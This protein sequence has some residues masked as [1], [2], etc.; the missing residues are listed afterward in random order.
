M[1]TYYSLMA[2]LFPSEDPNEQYVH[3]WVGIIVLLVI[4][5]LVALKRGFGS[6][7]I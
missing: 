5:Y 1:D 4:A 2:R 6:R 7:A 3:V